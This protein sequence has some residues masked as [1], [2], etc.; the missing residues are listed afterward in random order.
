MKATPYFLMCVFLGLSVYF[1]KYFIF[2]R[3]KL[4]LKN[5]EMLDS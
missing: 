3:K 5:E 2:R 1:Q 4:R